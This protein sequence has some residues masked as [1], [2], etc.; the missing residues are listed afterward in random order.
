MVGLEGKASKK[1][2]KTSQ[3]LTDLKK[4]LPFQPYLGFPVLG[5]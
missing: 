3:I 4:N 2:Y 1:K 5:S